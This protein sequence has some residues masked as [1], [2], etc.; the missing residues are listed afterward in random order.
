MVTLKAHILPHPD[1]Q[2]PG[3]RGSKSNPLLKKPALC[4]FLFID[5]Q[6]LHCY[7]WFITHKKSD[8][9][10]SFPAAKQKLSIL[11]R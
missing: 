10:E 1:L 2:P 7:I 6:I 4:G 5:F 8:V 11:L 3:C 9:Y